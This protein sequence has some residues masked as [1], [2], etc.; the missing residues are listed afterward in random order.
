MQDNSCAKHYI[1]IDRLLKQQK[2]KKRKKKDKEKPK[3]LLMERTK[4]E[5]AQNF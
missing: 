2:K 1:S 5:L 3:G 4:N